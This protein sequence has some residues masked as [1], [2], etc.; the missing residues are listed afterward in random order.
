MSTRLLI[1][2]LLLASGAAAE[3]VPVPGTERV[4]PVFDRATLVCN[5]F[6]I[7]RRITHEERVELGGKTIAR[8]TFIATVGIRDI[9]KGTAPP[10]RS[11]FVKFD[12][13]IPSTRASMPTLSE[14][15][16]GLM[17]L[18][19]SQTDNYDFADAFIGVTPFTSLSVQ[20]SGS[21]ILKLQTALSRSLQEGDRGDKI[22]AMRLL[23]GCDELS[24]GSIS[25]LK[26]FTSASDPELALSSIA[27][28]LKTNVPGTVQTLANYLTN[29]II[30]PMPPAVLSI[31]G[32]LQNVSDA[33]DL[34][35][36]EALTS[37]Q[38]LSIKFAALES[39]RKIRSPR[40]AKTLVER[41]EDPN[42]DVRFLAV[43]TLAEIFSK[44]GDYS[45]TMEMFDKNPDSYTIRWK[46]WW[47]EE[48]Q[49]LYR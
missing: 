39:I 17:F 28:L 11:V 32:E 46:N 20:N 31:G 3:I 49:Y 10:G 41:L 13:E 45:P 23:E 15:E 18:T 36:L 19:L 38:I 40:S 44:D 4:A 5:C 9:Y 26:S 48:G 42:T 34:P 24:P 21:G 37:S 35:S 33:E 22:R 1:G 7:S 47:A 14:A 12:E 30:V 29:H 2:A 43:I 16:S 27:V 6:V 25:I 8:R